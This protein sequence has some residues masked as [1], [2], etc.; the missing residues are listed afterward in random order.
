MSGTAVRTLKEASITESGLNPECLIEIRW[1]VPSETNV[2]LHICFLMLSCQKCEV[3]Q[4]PRAANGAEHR[5][6][7]HLCQLNIRKRP[8]RWCTPTETDRNEAGKRCS[9]RDCSQER[10]RAGP[11][12]F[13]SSGDAQHAQTGQRVSGSRAVL[14]SECS[15]LVR[16]RGPNRFRASR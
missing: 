3:A 16:V 9:Y 13:P 10:P 11:G 2:E 15:A 12:S 8:C 1:K 5:S 6:T 7:P 14:Q 4:R